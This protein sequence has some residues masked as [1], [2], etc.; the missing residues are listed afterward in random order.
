VI[1]LG[2]VPETIRSVLQQAL[3]GNPELRYE[4]VTA[5]GQALRDTLSGPISETTHGLS[6]GQ[7]SNRACGVINQAE[8]KFCK[9]CG[10]SLREACLKCEE[11]IPPWEKF[12]P[13]CGG[14]LDE[15]A[16]VRREE[17]DTVKEQVEDHRRDCRFEEAA[18]VAA[19]LGEQTHSRLRDYAEWSS[20][21]IE[22]IATEKREREA[23][24]DVQLAEARRLVDADE[25]ENAVRVI[26]QVPPSLRTPE[27][28]SLE[29]QIERRNSELV[30]RMKELVEEA[31]G[32]KSQLEKLYAEGDYVDAI[33]LSEG[34]RDFASGHASELSDYI[35]WTEEQLET[36]QSE[37]TAWSRKRATWLTEAQ[38][39]LD[40][41]EFTSV[42][43]LLGQL[44]KSM[45]S[46]P[47]DEA[48][49]TV[50]AAR[51]LKRAEEGLATQRE[52]EATQQQ[53]E[54][55]RQLIPKLRGEYQHAQAI[56]ELEPLV[57]I[58]DHKLTSDIEWANQQ[59]EVICE[60][61]QGLLET[62]NR[63][64]DTARESFEQYKYD[65]A[66]RL[67]NQIPVPIQDAG[68]VALVADAQERASESAELLA[69]IRER[70]GNKNLEGLLDEVTRGLELH[71]DRKD[72]Q[73]L[74]G[75]LVAREARRD[76][77]RNRNT[78][79]SPKEDMLPVLEPGPD[80]P[81]YLCDFLFSRACDHAVLKNFGEAI[82]NFSEVIKLDPEFANAYSWRGHLHASTGNAEQASTDLQMAEKLVP[83]SSK[84]PLSWD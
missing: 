34:L 55:L 60:E 82:R 61:Y 59:L 63:L 47:G 84:P 28:D 54:R 53:F 37:L 65:E 15:L 32:Q 43:E 16:T 74:Q 12:C 33:A 78:K 35:P 30:A 17:F 72:L 56:E 76:E 26:E 71:P 4:S 8:R 20:R 49:E 80:T 57:T 69:T 66:V 23:E 11:S 2:E 50:E 44:P 21:S 64:R 77:Q 29:Q 10:E 46:E 75:Q 52:R 81:E 36:L 68:T 9:E 48:T 31:E 18:T 40:A 62:Q 7:C 42:I 73:K 79:R 1:D 45:R 41:E 27:L 39:L 38:S 51:L 58:N 6:E 24:R 13:L 22:E 70:I 3:K 67:L 5:F 19:T 83:G 14:N 25:L